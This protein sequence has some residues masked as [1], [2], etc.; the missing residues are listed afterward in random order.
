MH[1]Y[2]RTIDYS[3]Y[4]TANRLKILIIFFEFLSLGTFYFF[5]QRSILLKTHLCILLL[6][7]HYSDHIPKH[8]LLTIQELEIFRKA[9]G[10][11]AMTSRTIGRKP[12]P[13]Y[14]ISL[15]NPNNYHLI[16]F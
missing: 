6:L 1:L 4:P 7:E 11:V 14:K 16:L 8:I 12:P 10:L 5:E 13:Y 9:S 3:Y 2:S 15:K